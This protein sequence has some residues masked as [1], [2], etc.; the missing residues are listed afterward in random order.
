MVEDIPQDVAEETASQTLLLL[1]EAVRCQEER[2]TACKRHASLPAD[3]EAKSVPLH[4][5]KAQGAEEV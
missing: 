1:T 2:Q 5:T 3:K 4:A